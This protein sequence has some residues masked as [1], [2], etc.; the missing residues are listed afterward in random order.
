MQFDLKFI[1]VVLFFVMMIH[2][3]LIDALSCYYG[4]TDC[5]ASCQIQNC[6]TG[7]C[8]GDTCVCSRCATGKSY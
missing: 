6:A 2:V 1:Y 4:R 3:N 7:Y 5:I 8:R